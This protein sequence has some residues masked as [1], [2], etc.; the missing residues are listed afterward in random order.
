MYNVIALIIGSSALS[1]FITAIFNRRK[2]HTEA[3]SLSVR[4]A[5]ELEDRATTRYRSAQEALDA[6]QNA[7]NVARTEIHS[8]EDYVD[9]L[10]GLLDLAGIKYPRQVEMIG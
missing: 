9:V 7:L 6:A 1:A 3:M 5:L 10:H 2:L 8:L 4:T